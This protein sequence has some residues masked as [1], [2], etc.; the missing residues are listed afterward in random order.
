M[1]A[2]GLRVTET[3][4]EVARAV[5]HPDV[6]AIAWP[7]MEL[8]R[9]VTVGTLPEALR[10]ELSLEWGPGREHL[11]AG[12]SMAIRRLVPLLPALAHRFPGARTGLLREA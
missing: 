9:L 6:P 8:V 2:E 3:C 1:L 5:L 7:A 10:E 12:S 4:R 11:L